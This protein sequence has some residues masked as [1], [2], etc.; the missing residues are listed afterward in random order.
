[1]AHPAQTQWSARIRC[2]EHALGGSYSVLLFLGPVPA[3]PDEWMTAPSF[4]GTF[5]C[6]TSSGP[7][8]D[9][10]KDKEVQG[11]VDLSVGLS[12]DLPE[13]TAERVVPYLRQNLH[14]RVQKV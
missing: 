4:A 13:L 9:G 3:S 1:M 12:Y 14:W 5:D 2:K 6:F 7:I 10:Q 8:P 11:F